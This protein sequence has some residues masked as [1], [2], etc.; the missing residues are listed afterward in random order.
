MSILVRESASDACEDSIWQGDLDKES[1]QLFGYKAA[2]Q[3]GNSGLR[4]TP[5]WNTLKK[6]DVLPF[7]KESVAAYQAARERAAT[8]KLAEAFA[9]IEAFAILMTVLSCIG[10]AI[11]V[12]GTNE[13]AA[14][15]FAIVF[16]P[17]VAFSIVSAFFRNRFGI[18]RRWVN[19]SI[20]EYNLPIPAFALQTA[21]DV[22]RAHPELR[23][24]FAIISLE[25]NRAVLDPFLA[26]ELDGNFYYLEVWD[27]P[28]FNAKR[29][30]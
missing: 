10:M 26:M 12:L 29:E 9:G 11:G 25:Q 24:G 27:E 18:E 19:R 16:F 13:S 15:F 4:G 3:Q 7:T 20:R 6:L 5:I 8:P 2:V 1:F 17:L 28:D 22:K 23:I 21:V 30:V 14:F